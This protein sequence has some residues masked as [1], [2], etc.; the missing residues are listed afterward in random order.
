MIPRLQAGADA[1]L[2]ETP[3]S[4]EELIEIGE[5]TTGYR[6]CYMVEGG[7][8]PMLTPEELKSYGYHLIV[9]PLTTLYASAHAMLDVLK[10]LKDEGSTRDHLDR[11]ATFEEFNQLL[12]LGSWIK[13]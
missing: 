1:S 9:H 13:A 5:K 11:M 7:V 3:R 10:A 12:S 4:L 6:V 2:V 8:T